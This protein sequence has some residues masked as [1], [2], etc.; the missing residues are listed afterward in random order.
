MNT[1]YKD[2]LAIKS[3]DFNFTKE[4]IDFLK[5][6]NEDIILRAIPGSGKTTLL[7]YKVKQLLVEDADISKIQCISYTNV[8]VN[9]LEK[10]CKSTLTGEQFKKVEFSTF[11]SF[12]YE[13]IIKPFGYLYYYKGSRIYQ[14]L[15][16]WETHGAKLIE[17]LANIPCEN[18]CKYEDIKY[19][20]NSEFHCDD[21]KT[22]RNFIFDL[23]KNQKKIDYNVYVDE[24]CLFDIRKTK[25]KFVISK[26]EK[27]REEYLSA[28]FTFLRKNN[29]ID[30][31]L[32]LY[33]SLR[34]VYENSFVQEVINSSF[35]YI[36]I[37]EF[38]DISD[39]QF[40]IINLLINS[41]ISTES[42]PHWIFIGDPNQSIYGFAGAK[43]DCMYQMRSLIGSEKEIQLK[44]SFRCSKKVFDGARNVYNTNLDKFI[45]S[46]SNYKTKD[47]LSFL[48]YL[49][50]DTEVESSHDIGT[51]IYIPE[52]TLSDGVC[53]IGTDRFDS[54]ETYNKYKPFD[55]EYSHFE[56][57]LENYKVKF[58]YR[59]INLFTQYLIVK[60]NFLNSIGDFQNSLSEYIYLFEKLINEELLLERQLLNKN[61]FCLSLEDVLSD[62]VDLFSEYCKFHKRI[63]SFLE[64]QGAGTIDSVKDWSFKLNGELSY[65]VQINFSQFIEYLRKL[66]KNVSSIEIKHL[67]K[68]KGLQYEAIILKTDKIPYRISKKNSEAECAGDWIDMLLNKD[69]QCQKLEEDEIFQCIEELNKIYV[70]I[71]RSKSDVSIINDKSVFLPVEF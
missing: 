61:D 50:V 71:T 1:Y 65:D 48:E 56:N 28:Y 31:N 30:F 51:I 66:K 4:Q 8:T 7:A 70:M 40:K 11:H 58:G 23:E 25:K 26:P 18:G 37:D 43:M 46:L 19:L 52:A 64:I 35:D 62:D 60:Y 54:L 32:L 22:K 41:R 13:Y 38:Q 57:L 16:N 39:L 15:F 12:C 3:S 55:N 42:N 24:N 21:C 47:F 69:V 29:L 53:F 5:R 20:K 14:E 68:I 36:C 45:E 9:D 34:L 27:R 67:H 6:N 59:Y 63:D 2:L 44:I 10:K 49:K 17:D 33:F